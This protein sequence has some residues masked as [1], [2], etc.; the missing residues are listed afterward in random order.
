MKEGKVLFF[1]IFGADENEEK[2]DK[3]EGQ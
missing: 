1:S 2:K 3:K